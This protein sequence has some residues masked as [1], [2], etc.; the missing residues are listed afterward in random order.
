MTHSIHCAEIWGGV[1]SIVQDV[2]TPGLSASI[3]SRSTEGEGGGDIYYLSVCSYD[4]LT[5]IAIVDVRGHGREVLAISEW[6]YA[7]LLENMNSMNGA[8]VLAALNDLVV[9]RGFHAISTAAILTFHR[10]ENSLHYSYAGH[11]PL[12]LRRHP[13]GWASVLT[14]DLPGVANLPLGVRKGIRYDQGGL[15]V[16]PGD[17]FCLYTDG[18]TE[19]TDSQGELWGE[20]RLAALLAESDRQELAIARDRI[21]HAFQAFAGANAPPDDCT[22]LLAEVLAPG[23]TLR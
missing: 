4:I 7:L 16:L 12:L 18:L 3:F 2:C 10:Q 15:T 6:L 14:P 1:Q 8:A 20:E 22:F 13:A 23:S 21:I 11:P 5:R 17:R 19:N 9:D